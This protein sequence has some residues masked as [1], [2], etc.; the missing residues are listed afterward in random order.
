MNIYFIR[1]AESAN[2][3]LAESA[4][5]DT[6]VAT[7]SFD[8]TITEI[9]EQQ[10]DALAQHL[11]EGRQPEFSRK[12]RPR[13]QGYGLTRLV[14]SPMQRTL[15]TAAPTARRLGLPLE[16]WTDI[17]E[18]GGLFEGDPRMEEGARAHSGLARS[19]IERRF[20]GSVLPKEVTERG[21]WDRGYEEMEEAEE[22]AVVVGER[23]L[24]LAEAQPQTQLGFVT[25]GTF[26][27]LLLRAL[28]GV[29]A[30]APMYFFHAN[31]G[32]TRVEFADDGF[33]V[34]RYTNRTAHLPADLMTR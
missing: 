8:P 5:F 20:P 9:G 17:Y 16:V 23:L 24:A 31:T 30:E 28:L 33:R 32:I 34:L 11:V 13:R 21:W 1:H 2:N 12:D 3:R 15:Q 14:C 25:H 22:R 4:D 26:L 27:N 18:Q 7:R 29:P 6:Y 10:A 19:E